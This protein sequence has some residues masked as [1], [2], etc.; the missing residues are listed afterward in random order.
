MRGGKPSGDIR[1]EGRQIRWNA[2]RFVSAA[3]ARQ[4]L[5]TA[6]LRDHQARAQRLWQSIDGR[7]HHIGEYPRA[8]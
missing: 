5:G 8:E 3:R 6:L 7:R 4:I 1:D 2:R